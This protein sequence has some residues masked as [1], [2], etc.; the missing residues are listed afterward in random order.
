MLED[1]K[2]C[3]GP[4][5]FAIYGCWPG[6]SNQYINENIEIMN[7]A[8]A[9]SCITQHSQLFTPMSL[10]EAFYGKEKS[11]RKFMYLSYKVFIFGFK[12]DIKSSIFKADMFT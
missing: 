7:S 9:M 12:F 8:L 1:L 11:T 6:V 3:Y 5:S 4:K 10:Q 2:D